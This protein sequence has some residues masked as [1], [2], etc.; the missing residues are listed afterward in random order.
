MD[1]V[2]SWRTELA[3]LSGSHNGKIIISRTTSSRG[4]WWDNITFSTLPSE[5]TQYLE[6]WFKNELI[7]HIQASNR[8]QWLTNAIASLR[9]DEARPTIQVWA[10]R[11][12]MSKEDA[13]KLLDSYQ[14]DMQ[15]LQAIQKEMEQL[16]G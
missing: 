16:R 11:N 13:I 10:N 8:L 9:K 6:P 15:K 2:F 1:Y 14:A 7:S 4:P 12:G 3:G 5:L